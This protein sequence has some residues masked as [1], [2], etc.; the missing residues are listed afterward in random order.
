MSLHS[1]FDNLKVWRFPK[2]NIFSVLKTEREINI[3]LTASLV[4]KELANCRRNTYLL[5]LIVSEILSKVPKLGHPINPS[6]LWIPLST[7]SFIL[8]VIDKFIRKLYMTVRLECGKMFL[9]K[10]WSKIL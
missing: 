6:C 7:S 5:S 9:N 1:S 2:C 3:L 4:H 8:K 10:F